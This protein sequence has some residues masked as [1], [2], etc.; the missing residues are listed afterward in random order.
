VKIHCLRHGNKTIRDH[1]QLSQTLN[2]TEI[3][4]ELKHTEHQTSANEREV[5]N[6]SCYPRKIAELKD[7]SDSN[8]LRKKKTNSPGGACNTCYFVEINVLKQSQMKEILVI[9]GLKSFQ[10]R[11]SRSLRS[12][13]AQ[14]GTEPSC[15]RKAAGSRSTARAVW[16]VLS[17]THYFH[18][19]GVSAVSTFLPCYQVR[20]QKRHD[21]VRLQ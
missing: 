8:G 7:L 18:P 14:P 15:Q 5:K 6:I 3:A 19:L 11:S 1:A 13:G 20:T 12:W 16:G 21:R 9:T 4:E 17:R 10:R 2:T